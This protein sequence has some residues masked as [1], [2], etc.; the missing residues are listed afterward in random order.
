MKKK[1]KQNKKDFDQ[2][3][4]DGLE[5]IDFST[6]EITEGLSKVIKIPPMTIP[7]WLNAEI[8]KLARLQANPKTAII[9]QLLVE[10]LMSRK[11]TI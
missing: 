2:R 7:A 10:A 6:G 11:K 1:N 5:T 9:R 4:D 3:F 8:E